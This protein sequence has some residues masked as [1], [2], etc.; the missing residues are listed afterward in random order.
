MTIDATVVKAALD[1]IVAIGTLE[2][3]MTETKLDDQIVAFLGHL[4]ADPD[5]VAFLATVLNFAVR[6]VSGT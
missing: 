6:K 4:A 1:K 5:A 3:S 2:A